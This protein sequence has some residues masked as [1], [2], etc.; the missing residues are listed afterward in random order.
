MHN[1]AS[2]VRGAPRLRVEQVEVVEVGEVAEQLASQA[3]QRGHDRQRQPPAPVAGP[4]D[5]LQ[6]VLQRLVVVE[7]VLNR[8]VVLVVQL[9]LDG[10]ERLDV[11][12]AAG[13]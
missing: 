11:L 12:R 9:Q 13:C 6:V 2:A 4:V 5:E 1:I 8:A 10:L 7:P 3:V